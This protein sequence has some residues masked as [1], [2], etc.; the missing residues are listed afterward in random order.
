MKWFCHDMMIKGAG[1]PSSVGFCLFLATLLVLLLTGP[2]FAEEV[3]SG[4]W[5]GT[6]EFSLLTA[7]G[8]SSTQTGSLK[9]EARK[10][11]AKDRWIGRA[12]GLQ[13]KSEGEKTAENYYLNGE[14]NYRF[15]AR[16]YS[17][18]F[19]GWEKDPLAGLDTRLTGRV[20]LGHEYLK[21]A[22]DTLLGEVGVAYVYENEK[23]ENHSFPEG[24]IYGKYK[25][26]FREG[27]AFFQEL[28]GL[29]DLT[30][31]TNFRI[32]SV[33]GLNVALN[34]EWAVKMT[35]TVHYDHQPAEGFLKTDTFTETSLVYHF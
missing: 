11:T 10:E 29:Q 14:Y 12:G 30:M 5:G 32:N 19:I 24:R 1:S 25:H 34:Q 26:V 33:S 3:P 20:G 35:V 31:L 23:E 9:A 22:K 7:R 28:E 13:S 15:N 8:N 21:T 18:Y 2:L 17:S 27:V 6:V 16:T 4:Q